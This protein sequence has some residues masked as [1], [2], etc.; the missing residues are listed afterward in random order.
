MEVRDTIQREIAAVLQ[1]AG[2]PVP[3][4]ADGQPLLA[5]GLGLDSLDFAVVVV[6]LE[7]QLGRDPFATAELERFPVTFGELVALYAR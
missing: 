7:Q 3:A 2:K 1:D 5:G 6:R 4:F